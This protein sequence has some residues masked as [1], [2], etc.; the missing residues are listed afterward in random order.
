MNKIPIAFVDDHKLLRA[1]LT[2][3][4]NGFADYVI[5]IQAGDGADFINQL[6][7]KGLPEIVLLDIEMKGMNGY[8]TAEWLQKNHPGIKII[9]VS[10]L[11]QPHAVHRLMSLGACAFISKADD[12]IIFKQA[13]DSVRNNDFYIGGMLAAEVREA[14]QPSRCAAKAD[15]HLSGKEI[16]YLEW[17]GTPLCNK[18]IAHELKLTPKQTEHLKEKLCWKLDVSTRQEL[19][20]FAMR[21][22]IPPPADY[23]LAAAS[24]TFEPWNV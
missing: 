16:I 23:S 3:L 17:C 18:Q 2:E 4:I 11:D 1:G 22:G 8:K 10:Q 20:V 13:L 7:A 12:P 21:I 6:P 19:A 24:S 14:L 15:Y 9:V 5:T